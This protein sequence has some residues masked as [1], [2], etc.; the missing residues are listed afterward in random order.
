MPR[1]HP[2][3]A[4]ALA[5][6]LTFAVMTSVADAASASPCPVTL[7]NH[8]VPAGAGFSREGF[9]YGNAYLRAY[10]TWARGTL[11]AGILPGGG[12]IATIEP[13]GSIRAKQGWWRGRK[14]RLVITGRRLDAAAP[15]LRAD[16][17]SGYGDSGFIA[18]AI[19]FPTAGCWRVNGK[20]GTARL[21]YVVKVIK[22]KS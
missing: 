15:P 22:L 11:R 14:G 17:P 19:N 3:L 21:T 18:T 1:G 16:I 10:L 12:A 6:V 20:Q 9:N 13:D 2:A 8:T 4:A 5:L 7:P